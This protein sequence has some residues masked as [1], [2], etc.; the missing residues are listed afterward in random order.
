MLTT[1]IQ[2]PVSPKAMNIS[3]TATAMTSV[4]ACI[5]TRKAGT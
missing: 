5:A 2:I 4:L 1:M 3:T